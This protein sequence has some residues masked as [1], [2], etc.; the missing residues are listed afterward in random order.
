MP[1]QNY[2]KGFTINITDISGN[3]FTKSASTPLDLKRNTIKP[4][5]ALKIFNMINEFP[6]D[7]TIEN[8]EYIL[9]NLENSLEYGVTKGNTLTI[10]NTTYKGEIGYIS[11]GIYQ[12]GRDENK[13]HGNYSL[14]KVTIKDL[15]VNS[16]WGITNN[17]RVI[18]IGAFIYG[19]TSTLKNC[20]MTRTKLVGPKNS[21][22]DFV[23]QNN[24]VIDDVYDCAIVN[25]VNATIDGGEYGKLYTYE[26]AKTTIKGDVKINTLTTATITN[27]GGYLKIDGGTIEKI[28]V[29]PVGASYPPTIEIN[30]GATVKK[31]DFGG[32]KTTNFE[33]NS[34]KEITIVNAATTE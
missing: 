34:G 24:Q 28:V 3:T 5:A 9:G 12:Y 27:A 20:T 14:E 7:A 15:T 11:F 30:A 21:N 25:F 31:I 33:N 32:S 6:S 17:G 23:N 16:K 18:S 10:K 19:G 13:G 26:H 2:E 22:G 29:I 4:M 1:V 8:K